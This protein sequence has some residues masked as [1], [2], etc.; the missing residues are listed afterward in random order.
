M[1]TLTNSNILKL[2]YNLLN[3]TNKNFLKAVS[4]PKFIPDIQRDLVNPKSRTSSKIMF[5]YRKIE[6]QTI[7][8]KNADISI[9]EIL[10]IFAEQQNVKL[11][12]NEKKDYRDYQIIKD[13]RYGPNDFLINTLKSTREDKSPLTILD[14]DLN[15]DD[16]KSRNFT[17]KTNLNDFHSNKLQVFLNNFL[18]KTQLKKF[19]NQKLLDIV[20]NNPEYYLKNEIGLYQ[21]AASIIGVENNTSEFRF[22]E[23]FDLTK[24]GRK[25]ISNISLMKSLNNS[26]LIP[27]TIVKNSQ[28]KFEEILFDKKIK[29]NLNEINNQ[30]QNIDEEKLW[31]EA[32]IGNFDII[33]KISLSKN[34][35]HNFGFVTDFE[36]WR[37]NY[38]KLPEDNLVEDENNY[39]SSLKYKINLNSLKWDNENYFNLIKI[40]KGISGIT[41]SQIN[42]IEV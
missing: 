42:K 37:I 24:I 12:A 28:K 4:K 32:I 6:Y 14:F 1:K 41:G 13:G 38:Y 39:H 2:P 3:L 27:I 30:N 35:K 17:N 18:E 36:T 9:K 20:K 5:F 15:M 10:S 11:K 23:N 26:L 29:Q 22:N 7:L 16:I 25:S 33:R 8:S 21:I 19:N 34:I 31:N 40:V